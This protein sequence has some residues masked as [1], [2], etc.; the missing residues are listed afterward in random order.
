MRRLPV[1]I[2]LAL[3]L[4]LTAC[5]GANRG[6]KLAGERFVAAWGDTA[7]MHAVVQ[8][9][10]AMRDSLSMPWQRKAANRAFAEVLTAT[11]RDSLLQAAHVIALSPTEFAQIKCEPMV[12]LLMHREFDT[13]SVTDY[14]SLLH[15]LAYTVGNTRHAE[16]L[17]STLDAQVNQLS[18]YEQMCVYSQATRPAALGAALARD[19]CKPDADQ[20]D[21]Q[22]RID[23]LRGIYNQDEFAVFEQAFNQH[24]SDNE[25]NQQTIQNQ[26]EQQ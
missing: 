6:G 25:N 9:F 24:R 18:I 20:A 10:Y 15:W 4:L 22:A 7:A 19:A 12:T 8:R 1:I 26:Q 14:L 13:D 3:T 21:I 17:D 16:V 2:M 5:D 23:A 11:G